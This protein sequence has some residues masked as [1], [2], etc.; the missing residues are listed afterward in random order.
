MLFASVY[1][2]ALGVTS[3]IE[4]TVV[5]PHRRLAWTP[6]GKPLDYDAARPKTIFRGELLEKMG[7]KPKDRI[8]LLRIPWTQNVTPNV[9]VQFPSGGRR[10]AGT[11]LLSESPRKSWIV[12]I[13]VPL[14]GVKN[15]DGTFEFGVADGAWK[16]A[17]TQWPKAKRARGEA[18]NVRLTRPTPSQSLGEDDAKNW[19]LTSTLSRTPRHLAWRLLPYGAGERPME[20]VGFLQV[21]NRNAWAYHFRAKDASSEVTRID[22]QRRP[23]VWIKFGKLLLDPVE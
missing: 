14:S 21:P 10:E 19:A 20:S 8:V 7:A 23:F 11:V 5:D 6:D 1:F 17:G 9:V 16:T 18:F 13:K 22:L 4:V 15:V 2:L 12:P 3:P